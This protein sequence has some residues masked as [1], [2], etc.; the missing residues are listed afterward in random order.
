MGEIT[1]HPASAGSLQPKAPEPLSADHDLVG[2]DCGKKDLNDWLI[3]NARRSEGRTARTY[4]VAIGQRV[5][6]YYCLSTGGVYRNQ[7]PKRYQRNSPD[8]IPIIV[9]GRL[10]VVL[11]MQV[12]GFGIG[13]LKDA[14]KRTLTVAEVVGARAL[15]VHAIDDEAARYY[16]HLNFLPSPL[17]ERTFVLP[18]DH[19]HE[20]LKG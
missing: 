12:K 13:L 20:A 18:L 15:V 3:Q 6:G 2:F 16:Q 9:L 4:V 1:Q 19:I 5:V 7:M 8:E 17:N 11:G 10:A 14:I